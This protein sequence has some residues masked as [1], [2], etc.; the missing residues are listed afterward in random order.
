[1]RSPYCDW[2][3][4]Y[5]LYAA[6]TLVV[7][8]VLYLLFHYV[9]LPKRSVFFVLS[10]ALIFSVILIYFIVIRIDLINIQDQMGCLGTHAWYP[11]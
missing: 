4:S 2:L 5:H 7:T 8:L 1:M 3:Q 11:R 9:L 6:V 10:L